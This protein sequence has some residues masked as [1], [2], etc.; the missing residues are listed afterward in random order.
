MLVHQFFKQ[1]GLPVQFQ[2]HVYNI[3]ICKIARRGINVHLLHFRQLGGCNILVDTR[4]S[5]PAPINQ[6][7]IP[8]AG[9]HTVKGIIIFI[10][11]IVWI[12]AV[13]LT[14]IED[15][16]SER[17]SCD[18][19]AHRDRVRETSVLNPQLHTSCVKATYR[20]YQS[21]IQIVTRSLVQCGS[22]RFQI[23]GAYYYHQMRVH[24]DKPI[25]DGQQ[26]LHAHNIVAA[27]DRQRVCTTH[28]IPACIMDGVGFGKPVICSHLGKFSR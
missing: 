24:P 20:R 22:L 12:C 27:V 8:V 5:I 9:W 6:I 15:R 23:R 18:M 16:R 7:K 28:I 2:Y 25:I 26:T 3:T 21:C 13:E 14:V 17:I 4:I 19:V 10:I 1:R 11:I